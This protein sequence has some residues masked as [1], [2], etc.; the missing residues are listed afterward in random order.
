[1]VDLTEEAKRALKDEFE[2]LS[3]RYDKIL[4]ES[5]VQNWIFR[6][7]FLLVLGGSFY[8]LYRFEGVI[9]DRITS[10]AAVFDR[11]Y[12]ANILAQSGQ[13]RSALQEIAAFTDSLR[14][15]ESGGKPPYDFDSLKL[16]LSQRN[17]FNLTVITAVAASTERDPSGQYVG[18]DFWNALQLSDY[19][20]R[21]FSIGT[22]WQ[23][24]Q[25]INARLARAYFRFADSKDHIALAL[26]YFQQATLQ[27]KEINEDSF[28]YERLLC[29]AILGDEEGAIENAKAML[30]LSPTPRGTTLSWEFRG[31]EHG[32]NVANR[33]QVV[34]FRRDVDQA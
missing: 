4:V 17:F 24:G 7:T 23:G 16:T 22:Q 1:M 28:A 30:R 21:E 8:G 31:A 11:I 13:Y 3:A 9:D 26:K 19:F 14:S 32:I 27:S 29:A 12:L 15:N 33:L 34:N 2:K 6:I 18:K 25:E 5:S 10:R 20:K